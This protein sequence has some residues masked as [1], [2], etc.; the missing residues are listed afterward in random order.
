MYN[1]KLIL[2]LAIVFIGFGKSNQSTIVDVEQLDFNATIEHNGQVIFEFDFSD[3][4]DPSTDLVHFSSNEADKF[5]IDSSKIFLFKKVNKESMI[6][7][8]LESTAVAK[9]D[10]S[11][12]TDQEIYVKKDLKN[13]QFNLRQ[14]KFDHQFNVHIRSDGYDDFE[15]FE[16]ELKNFIN[17]SCANVICI[18]HSDGELI[19][20]IGTSLDCYSRTINLLNGSLA[21]NSSESD[22]PDLKITKVSLHNKDPESDNKS[23]PAD[24]LNL[25]LIYAA[26]PTT[27]YYL[28]LFKISYA[29][30]FVVVV[31]QTSKFL[32]NKYRSRTLKI[33][34]HDTNQS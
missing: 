19:Y 23:K 30:F 26:K 20:G 12:F 21:S 14:H 24:S 11:Y 34:S 32:R 31:Y 33:G 13:Y 18:N 17:D 4:I 25:R 27:D 9:E 1:L 3:Q 10:F 28:I 15:Y 5:L 29:I 2:F 7:L 8:N 16:E 22:R 6:S